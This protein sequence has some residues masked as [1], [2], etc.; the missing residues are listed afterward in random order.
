MNM[1][2][3]PDEMRAAEEALFAGGMPS[4]DLMFVA[5][6]RMADWID[7]RVGGMNRHAVALVGPRNNGG[8]G[9]VTLALLT[10]RG[11]RCSAILLGHPCFGDLPGKPES[12]AQIEVADLTALNDAAVIL[13]GVYGIG[14]HTHI[15]ADVADAFRAARHARLMHGTP[16]VAID[17]PSGIDARTGEASPDAFTADVT[18]CLGLPKVGL[19]REPAATCV[20]ELVLLDI[21]VPEPVIADRPRLITES[22]VR[23]L[24]PTRRASAHKHTTGAL[25]VIGGDAAY[26]GAPRL[27]GA[28]ALRAGA[29]LVALAVPASHVPVIASA[30]PELVFVPLPA[31]ANL[32]FAAIRTFTATRAST[33]SALLIGPGLGRSART[34]QLLTFMLDVPPADST[35][36]DPPLVIDADALNWI[37]GLG[38]IPQALRP[39]RAV[40]TPHAGELARLME[41]TVDVVL[42]DP[43]Q[44]ARQAAGKFEQIIVLKTGY[45]A[46]ASPDGS[47]WLA[48]RATPEL[49]TAG[50][51]DVLA[52]L[53]GGL[54]AQGLAPGDAA[55]LGVY[56]GA[57]SGRAAR[58][59]SGMLGVIAG[60]VIDLIPDALTTLGEPAWHT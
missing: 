11:W 26:Y 35:L 2:V 8:D 54:L 22:T 57:M 18:L 41:T 45:T 10:E 14:S 31:D 51:G 21:G 12:F 47:V 42:S 44:V 33:L 36:A 59:R 34:E 38:R 1:L 39:G 29:G 9:L 50:T 48:P 4:S 49:A 58:A 24:M 52:G 23:P 43:L 27:S 15:P 7:K 32:A 13:D 19:V 6:S 55:R 3:T 5:S 40:L 56:A 53:I 30:V 46:I 25:L 28:A 16:L 20:G 17:V 37:A 60:D